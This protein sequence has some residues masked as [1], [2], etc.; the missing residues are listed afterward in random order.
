[1]GWFD[2]PKYPGVVLGD[3]PLDET[4]AFLKQLSRTYEEGLGRKLT[5]EELQA[6][7]ETCLRVN[8]DDTLLSNFEA[9]QVSAVHIKT[10]KRP[11]RQT[12]KAGDVFSIPLRSGLFA[13]GR[14]MTIGEKFGTLVEIFKETSPTAVATPRILESSRLFHPVYLNGL[15]AFRDLAYRIISSDPNYS[16]SDYESLKFRVG[17]PGLYKLKQGSSKSRPISTEEAVGIEPLSIWGPES[18]TARVQEALEGK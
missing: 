16:P 7:L 17:T 5:C 9:L 14:I 15:R 10:T 18:L 2:E 8:A 3:E 13:F 11:K 6:L 12:Y 4:Y 1:M